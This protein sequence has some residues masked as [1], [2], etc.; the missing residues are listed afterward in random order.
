MSLIYCYGDTKLEEAYAKEAAEALVAAY[1][2]H[3]WWVECKSGCLIIKHREASG[4]RN[5]VGMVR[6][7]AAL[8]HDARARKRDIV[9]KAGEMLERAGLKRGARTDDPVTHFDMDDTKAQKNWHRPIHL[10]TH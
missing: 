4:F 2:N 5:T 3:P 10:V 9:M 6:H 7:T 8:D 1:P